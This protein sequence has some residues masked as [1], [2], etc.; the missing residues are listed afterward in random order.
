[1]T[2][3]SFSVYTSFKAK[4]GMSSVFQNMK[5]RASVFGYQLDR[6][7]TQSQNV[8]NGLKNS[9]STVKLGITTIATAIATNT[10][11]QTLD[12]W[13]EKASDLQETLGK[14]NETF[15]TNSTMYQPVSPNFNKGVLPVVSVSKPDTVI[16]LAPDGKDAEN[17]FAVSEKIKKGG[18]DQH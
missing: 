12:S 13:V 2:S 10:V 14:T 5:N 7:K 16:C 1:M 4:D 18:Y 3:A 6:L 11:K 17:P 8:G 15:K 9:F